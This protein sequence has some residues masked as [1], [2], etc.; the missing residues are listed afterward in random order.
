MA[1]DQSL[2]PVTDAEL[3]ELREEMRAQRSE[4]RA[5]LAEQGVDVSGWETDD[6]EDD[7]EPSE[8]D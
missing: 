3:E 2:R 6:D 4:I 5:D 1:R 8:S 7:P